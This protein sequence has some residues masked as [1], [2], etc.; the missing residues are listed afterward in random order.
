MTNVKPHCFLRCQDK[1]LLHAEV[2]VLQTGTITPK[3]FWLRMSKDTLERLRLHLSPA[4]EENLNQLVADINA[5]NT[6]IAQF[7]Q[8]YRSKLKA[9]NTILSR[10]ES[11]LH[12]ASRGVC[13]TPLPW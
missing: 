8:K 1:A 11:V 3:K 12:T 9:I 5:F 6:R 13:Y 2:Q 4:E 7:S 10:Y